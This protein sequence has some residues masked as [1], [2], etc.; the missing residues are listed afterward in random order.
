[1]KSHN[2]EVLAVALG[3]LCQPRGEFRSW[4]VSIK[5]RA[6]ATPSP[7]SWVNGTSPG[8]SRAF[9]GLRSPGERGKDHRAPGLVRGCIGACFRLHT[10]PREALTPTRAR[11]LTTLTLAPPADPARVPLSAP[12]ANVETEAQSSDI[13]NPG[14]R[15]C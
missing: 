11:H 14:P 1:M 2:S 4:T 7:A 3:L 10:E 8:R 12:C 9:L 5:R 15:S 6:L 13:T